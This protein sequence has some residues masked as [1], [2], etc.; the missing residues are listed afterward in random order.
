MAEERHNRPEP[1]SPWARAFVAIV[2]LGVG[3]YGLICLIRGRLVTEGVVLEGFSARVVGGMIA[4]LATISLV[5]TL[6]PRWRKQ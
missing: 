5:R 4:A 6:H 2:V 1:L 3:A